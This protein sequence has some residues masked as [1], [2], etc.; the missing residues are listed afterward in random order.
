MYQKKKDRRKVPINLP[1]GKRLELS[2]G[3]HNKLQS[4]IVS[5]FASIFISEPVVLYIGDT[6]QKDLHID[7][8]YFEDLG[9]N[10]SGHDKL[11]DVV[12]LDNKNSY[13]FLIEAVTSHGPMNP[14]RVVELQ[15]IFK[16]YTHGLVFVSAFLD[17]KEFK[18][19]SKNIAWETE[20]WI[21]AVP[22]HMIHYN[23][24]KFILPK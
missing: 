20:V 16:N 13:I 15:E 21:A 17:F 24:D 11:P 23:G 12:I 8:K 2:P 3:K 5:D 14:K 4:L 18:K 19:H 9:V 22:Y 7:Y 6:A 1:D 10:I